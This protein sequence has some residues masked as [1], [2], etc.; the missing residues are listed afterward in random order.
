MTTESLYE[1]S[2]PTL[3]DIETLAREVYDRLPEEF[4]ERCGDILFRVEDFPD[5][6]V[7]EE[8]ELETQYDILGLFQG[9]ALTQRAES[10]TVPR[11]PNVVFLYRRPILD[12]WS[13]S[14]ILLGDIVT[15]VLIHEVGHHFGFSDDDMER[16][17][18]EVI[19]G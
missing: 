5:E 17:E 6:D 2:A 10:E 7:I 18:A 14:Q 15:H 11:E 13:E 8:M 3:D 4:R 9:V 16:I 12:E 19:D 1:M